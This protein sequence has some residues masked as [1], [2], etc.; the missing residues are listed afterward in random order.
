MN[1]EDDDEKSDPAAET[2]PPAED[3]DGSSHPESPPSAEAGTE[4]EAAPGADGAP[5]APRKPEPAPNAEPMPRPKARAPG[6][7]PFQHAVSGDRMSVFIPKRTPVL[8][9]VVVRWK[10]EDLNH[11]L[12]GFGFAGEASEEDLVAIKK[13]AK[14]GAQSFSEDFVVLRGI[15]IA[16]A[17]D[18]TY[19]FLNPP[20]KPQD[21][22]TKDVPFI[23]ILA[24]KPAQD[25]SDVF[26]KV[27]VAEDKTVPIAFEFVMPPDMRLLSDG[28]VVSDLSGQVKVAGKNMTFASVYTLDNVTAAEHQQLEFPCDVT[29]TCDLAGS[30]KW[31]VNGTLTVAGHWSADGVEVN[32]KAVAESGVQL[33]DERATLRINGDLRTTYVQMSR[34]GVTGDLTV[35]NSIMQSEVRVGGNCVC[36]G[37]PGT[38]MGSTV[39]CFGAVRAKKVGSDAGKHTEVNIYK[40]PAQH[41]TA[42]GVVT[43]G[44][45]MRVRGTTWFVTKDEAYEFE[46]P[47]EEVAEGSAEEPQQE[48]QEG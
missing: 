24:P 23:R 30:I 18:G 17:K 21:L 26:G 31:K 15:P 22:V 46:A 25:G 5:E 13:A 10:L 28:Y 42:I 35:E 9:D 16:G 32:G 43:V 38:I 40:T 37:T 33:A 41:K 20:G 45:K 44:T 6:L 12:A 14:S 7:A 11:Y 48:P 1:E 19:E 4:T 39:H 2:D 34:I 36:R 47:P 27:L 3:A 29:V 8:R